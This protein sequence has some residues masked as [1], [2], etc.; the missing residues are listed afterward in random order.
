MAPEEFEAAVEKLL[1]HGGARRDVEGNLSRGEDG[2]RQPYQRQR[3]H[4]LN[5][6]KQILDFADQAIGCRMVRLVRHF[7]DR[8]DDQPCGICDVCA[9]EAAAVRRTRRLNRV[10]SERVLQ[11]LDAL[12]WREGQTPRQLCERLTEGQVE[13]RGFERL[14]EA[15]A[16]AGLLELRED[17]FSR[18]GKVI[19]FRRVYLTEAGRKAGIGEVGVVRLRETVAKTKSGARRKRSGGRGG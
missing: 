4:K 10:E 12:R 18:D 8:D 7:G 11:V 16:G 9:P 19:P 1:V 13:R 3:E 17:A 15:M 6:L 2:W 14:L 5:E